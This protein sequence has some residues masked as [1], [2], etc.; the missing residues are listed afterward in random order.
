MPG[1]TT[2]GPIAGPTATAEVT[3]ATA[4]AVALNERIDVGRARATIRS[5]AG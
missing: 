4:A 5:A 3:A 2:A 1:T